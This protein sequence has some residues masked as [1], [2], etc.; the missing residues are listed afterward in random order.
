MPGSPPLYGPGVNHRRAR[1]AKL[2]EAVGA[3]FARVSARLSL[4]RPDAVERLRRTFPDEW[5]RIGDAE[6]DIVGATRAHLDGAAPWSAVERALATYEAA[7]A[8]AADRLR[9]W[10]AGRD[11]Q[12]CGRCGADRPL[13][14][15]H[16]DDGEALCG[17]C[18][19]S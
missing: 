9:R 16:F 10:E 7:W 17:R 6:D 13:I 2:R 15:I 8:R 14:L 3:A 5:L 11:V 19:R 4:L 1:S 12:V 18:W